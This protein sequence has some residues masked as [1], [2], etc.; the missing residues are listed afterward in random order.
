[1]R[2]ATVTDIPAVRTV[3]AR[4][5]F[6]DPLFEWIFT[7]VEPVV[8]ATAAWL[9]IFVESYVTNGQTT[10]A[11]AEGR[12]VGAAMWRHLNDPTAASEPVLPT[13]PGLVTAFVGSERADH[14]FSTLGR[15]IR[16]LTPTAPHSYLSFLAVDPDHQGRGHGRRL[17]LAGVDSA[18][19]Q[20]VGVHLETTK[21]TNVTF[22]RSLGFEVTD[23]H[24]LGGPHMW[25]MFRPLGPRVA[26]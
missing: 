16:S 19:S 10:V 7:G 1:M 24:D 3:L 22:Y 9:S 4:A 20:G 6:D 13:L 11:E 2:P 12:I 5:F 17:V 25:G 18:T 8:E 23:E 14:L 26:P 15:I 21:A